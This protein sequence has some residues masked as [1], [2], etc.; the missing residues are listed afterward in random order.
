VKNGNNARLTPAMQHEDADA[1]AHAERRGDAM[2]LLLLENA[3][4]SRQRVRRDV[5]AGICLR[6]GRG[7]GG[8][9]GGGGGEEEE[10]EEES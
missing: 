2:R 8:G 1:V 5:A 4:D 3:Q 7:G 10:E 9:G 6:G